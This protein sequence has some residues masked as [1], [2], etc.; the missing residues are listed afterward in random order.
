MRQSLDNELS[1]VS[2]EVLLVQAECGCEGDAGEEGKANPGCLHHVEQD[3]EQHKQQH[4]ANQTTN[5]QSNLHKEEDVVHPGVLLGPP[6][7]GSQK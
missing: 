1:S 6:R 5:D 7:Q 3:K 4:Q 2:D